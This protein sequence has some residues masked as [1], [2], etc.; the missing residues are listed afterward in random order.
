MAEVTKVVTFTD[1][2]FKALALESDKVVLVDFWAEW[3][4]PCKALNPTVTQLAEEFDGTVV[5]GKVNVDQNAETSVA[6]GI[7]SIPTLLIIKEGKV[8]E[9]I[10]GA[11]PKSHL[12]AKLKSHLVS[13]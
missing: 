1:D 4:G 3:C 11:M 9:E 13:A 2:N 12:E 8:V 6:Y 7:T 5:I 10:V